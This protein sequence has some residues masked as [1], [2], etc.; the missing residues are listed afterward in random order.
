LSGIKKKKKTPRHRDR[1]KVE[2]QAFEEFPILL[3]GYLYHIG[4]IFIIFMV[5]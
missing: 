1:L 4:I 5:L 3:I 2:N